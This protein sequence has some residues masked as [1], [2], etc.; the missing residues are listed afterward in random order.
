MKLAVDPRSI[1]DPSPRSLPTRSVVGIVLAL[2]AGTG[3]TVWGYLDSTE[4]RTAVGVRE[5]VDAAE[6]VL[7]V[8]EPEAIWMPELAPRGSSERADAG[9]AA[10]GRT[11]RA[12]E[13]ERRTAWGTSRNAVRTVR[14]A[15]RASVPSS[16]TQDVPAA[17]SAPRTTPAPAAFAPPEPH[18]EH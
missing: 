10:T 6:Q 13:P 7:E 15:P 4:P 18:A 2:L 1:F 9:T 12:A 3:L 5:E 8:S 11:K 16:P 14:P 17:S